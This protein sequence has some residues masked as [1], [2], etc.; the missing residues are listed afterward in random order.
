[1]AISL[2]SGQRL[3]EKFL[4]SL[5]VPFFPHPHGLLGYQAG[6]GDLLIEY[7]DDGGAGLH[8]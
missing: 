5:I 1:M 4:E 7:N 6:S 8:G 3:E 2:Y